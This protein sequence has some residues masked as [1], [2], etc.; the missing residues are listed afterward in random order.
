ME[1]SKNLGFV[2]AITH[3]TVELVQVQVANF[4]TQQPGAESKPKALGFL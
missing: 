3:A 4:I 1:S 2:S